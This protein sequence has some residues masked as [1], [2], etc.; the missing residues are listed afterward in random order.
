[1]NKVAFTY[2]VMGNIKVPSTYKDDK[3]NTVTTEYEKRISIMV[4]AKTLQDAL[5]YALV[6]SPKMVVIQVVK[7]GDIE[8]IVPKTFE[9]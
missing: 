6:H 1:M 3:G 4:T 7:R 9:N 2:E 8:L 5:S